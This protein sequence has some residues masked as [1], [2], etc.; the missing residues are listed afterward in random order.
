MK[1]QIGIEGI[2][3][4]GPSIGPMAPCEFDELKLLETDTSFFRPIFLFA[5]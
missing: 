1:T 4:K 2:S 5:L 3:Y